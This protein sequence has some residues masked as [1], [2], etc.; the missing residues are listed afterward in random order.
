VKLS[1]VQPRFPVYI[2]TKGRADSR[3]T[4]KALER[5]GVYYRIVVEEPEVEEYARWVDPSQILVLDESYKADYDLLW[6]IEEG[7]S[8]GP[9]PARN[10]IWDH[11]QAEGHEFHWTMDDNIRMFLRFHKGRQIEVRS[12]AFFRWQEDFVLRYE[13]VAMAGPHYEN[14]VMRKKKYPP[15]NLNR[16]IYSCNL[17]RNDV[18]IRWRGRYN[19]DTLLTLDLLERGWCTVLFNAFLQW[20]IATQVMKGGNT[21]AFYAEEGTLN[22]SEMLRREYPDITRVVWR[23]ERWHHYVNYSKYKDNVLVRR[24]A[25]PPA[26]DYGLMLNE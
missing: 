9:G 18:G 15:F 21:D 4:I 17:I 19:E 26:T 16:R 3:L 2:P 25:P 20:K 12:G 6:D 8:Y 14:F 23:W 5:M 11:A 24:D 22:K 1:K 10:F 7:Q 13:N